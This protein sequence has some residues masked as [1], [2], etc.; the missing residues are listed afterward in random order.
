MVKRSN[1]KAMSIAYFEHSDNDQ[2]DDK[3]FQFMEELLPPIELYLYPSP[4]VSWM[5]GTRKNG[6]ARFRP[7]SSLRTYAFVSAPSTGSPGR[8]DVTESRI[9]IYIYIYIYWYFRTSEVLRVRLGGKRLRE[10]QSERMRNWC[11]QRSRPLS[12]GISLEKEVC[13]PASFCSNDD[14]YSVDYN[15]KY[16]YRLKSVCCLHCDKCK[17]SRQSKADASSN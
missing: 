3:L 9:F 11:L 16:G 7:A 6:K 14:H 8:L 13:S 1:K 10:L 5:Q 12:S 4:C 17:F 15:W 2:R